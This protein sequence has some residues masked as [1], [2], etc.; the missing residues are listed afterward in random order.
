MIP[1]ALHDESDSDLRAVLAHELAH[2]V[3]RDLAWNLVHTV[4]GS[5]LFFHPFIWL[6]QR[7]WRLSQELACDEIALFTTKSSVADYAA[8]IL[9]LSRPLQIPR[10]TPS[11]VGVSEFPLLRR[12]LM[13]LRN[14]SS[15]RFQGSVLGSLALACVSIVVLA[16]WRPVYAEKDVDTSKPARPAPAYRYEDAAKNVMQRHKVP[17]Y[18][19]TVGG[20]LENDDAY[21]PALFM[22]K[23]VAMTMSI[24]PKSKHVITVGSREGDTVNLTCLWEQQVS[25]PRSV[26]GHRLWTS[27]FTAFSTD[28]EL[29]KEVSLELVSPSNAKE[30]KTLR[31]TVEARVSARE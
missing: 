5:A 8:L 18:K 12:R 27:N 14:H 7:D 25:K 20:L 6:L 23:G 1:I 4:V 29:G 28:V 15:S 19:L 9:R 10:L 11:A 2:I 31:V 24:G 3:R 13:M 26:D 17:Y 16:P 30:R 21:V 22:A